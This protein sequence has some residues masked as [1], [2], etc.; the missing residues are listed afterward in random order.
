[1]G[2]CV[3]ETC[4]PNWGKSKVRFALFYATTPIYL[5]ALISTILQSELLRISL[6]RTRVN[7]DKETQE[8]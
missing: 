6:P 5:N 4:L 1:M 7:K 3:T 2:R 8:P